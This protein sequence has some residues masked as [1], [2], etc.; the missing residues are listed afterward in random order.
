MRPRAWQRIKAGIGPSIHRRQVRFRQQHTC[1]LCT[2]CKAFQH[3]ANQLCSSAQSVHHVSM[4]K[5]ANRITP[6]I[7][8]EWSSSK[9]PILP[10]SERCVS[11]GT[12]SQLWI[13]GVSRVDGYFMKRSA[14]HNEPLIDLRPRGCLSHSSKRTMHVLDRPK[15]SVQAL[16]LRSVLIVTQPT[17]FLHASTSKRH[18][19]AAD[20]T[21]HHECCHGYPS[22]SV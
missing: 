10:R 14:S 6:Q 7:A 16:H 4:R 5:S 17:L 2:S 18:I 3:Y 21:F 19:R 1:G 12:H 22:R 8:F 13:R 20:D 9:H 15:Y 11:Q